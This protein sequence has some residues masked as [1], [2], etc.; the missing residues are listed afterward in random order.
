[1]AIAIPTHGK[2]SCFMMA[3]SIKLLCIIVV[4][5]TLHGEIC[6]THFVAYTCNLGF[7]YTTRS[8]FEHNLITILNSVVQDRYQTGLTLMCMAKVPNKYMASSNVKETPWSYN[9]TVS[10]ENKLLLFNRIVEM[11]AM[12]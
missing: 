9:A 12:V 1:M 8:A 3:Q 5:I 4:N 2:V 6:N 10:C 7:N 11:S